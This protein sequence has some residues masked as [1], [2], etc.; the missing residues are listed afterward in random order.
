MSAV[1]NIA[2]VIRQRIQSDF[3][4]LIP[5]E[6]FNAMTNRAVAEFTR[7]RSRG[8]GLSLS[9]AEMLIY[10]EIQ[11]DFLEHVKKLMSQPEF[12]TWK[13][14]KLSAPAF[15]EELISN[16]S[17]KLVSALFEGLIAQVMQ[18]IGYVRS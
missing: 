9:D 5:E 3:M 11:K 16:H 6:T 4:S 7:V 13:D 18:N 1:V 12:N 10:Q 8:N 15:V 14:G 17:D 2:D